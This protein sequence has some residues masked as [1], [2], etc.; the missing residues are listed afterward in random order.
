MS[1]EQARGRSDIDGRSDEYSLACV[2][3]ELLAGAAP[4][5]GSSAEQLAERPTQAPPSLAARR[6]TS[7]W[8]A[9]AVVARALALAPDARFETTT[10]FAEA[11]AASISDAPSHRCHPPVRR[12]ALKPIASSPD[13]CDRRGGGR[14]SPGLGSSRPARSSPLSY[15]RDPP[16]P[17]LSPA[18]PGPPVLAVL[19]F[20]NLGPPSDAYFADGLTDEVT[21]RLA[22]VSGLRVIARGERA[23]VQGE[24][25]RTAGDRARARRHAPAHG[26]RALG[27]HGRRRRWRGWYGARA[28][29]SG[30]GARC[31]PGDR[32][33]GA[34]RGVAR[35][36]LPRPGERRRPR[37]CV[38]PRCAP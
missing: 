11:L 29:A 25:E 26:H 18:P 28:G 15:M 38:A 17:R 10:A 12:P 13:P 33:D 1:P 22:A 8:R 9:D 23:A 16:A 19:P 32:V 20:E 21:G 30:A 35:G 5:T 24:H 14:C 6:P 2:A 36:R 27:A 37:R 31:R 4:F 3:F 34:G 7:R